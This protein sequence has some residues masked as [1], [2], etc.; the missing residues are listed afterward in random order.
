MSDAILFTQARGQLGAAT[1]ALR[2]ASTPVAK[3]DAATTVLR[4]IGTM[5][6]NAPTA[7]LRDA[8][9]AQYRILQPK[10]ALLRGQVTDGAPGAVLLELSKFS[11]A[12]LTF[13]GQ[14]LDGAGGVV[15]GIGSI[16]RSGPWLVVTL[17]VLAAIVLV[18]VGPQLVKAGRGK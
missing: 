9:L 17:L 14:V 10:A 13:G 6:A 18:K 15:Q 7:A 12:V 2:A 5:A 1:A 3:L 11:D 16:V 4:I 8:W